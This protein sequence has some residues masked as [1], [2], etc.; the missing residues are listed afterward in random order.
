[1]TCF[2]YLA[3]TFEADIFTTWV[4]AK[5]IVNESVSYKYLVSFFWAFQTVTTVGYGDF[6]INETSEYMLCLFW[7]IIGVTVYSFTLGNVSSIIADA[8]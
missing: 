7:M 1:M 6:S 4:G 5:D 2:W 8:D 3:A